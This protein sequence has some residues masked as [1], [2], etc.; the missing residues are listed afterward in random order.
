MKAENFDFFCKFLQKQTGTALGAG[1]EYLVES[2]LAPIARNHKLADTDAI[3]AA[4]NRVIP[5]V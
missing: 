3:V 1:K 2:R 4:M 5:P